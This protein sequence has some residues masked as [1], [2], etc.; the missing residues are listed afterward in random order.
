MYDHNCMLSECR[1]KNITRGG[2]YKGRRP[3][4]E[5]KG[6]IVDPFSQVFD[7]CLSKNVS[8]QVTVE[9]SHFNLFAKHILIPILIP[10][11]RGAIEQNKKQSV[12]RHMFLSHHH[13]QIKIRS[14]HEWFLR[15]FLTPTPV[16]VS[17][18][19]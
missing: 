5:G 12:A 6:Q 4:Q 14:E 9:W 18:S 10:V 7:D 19:M 17:K 13:L 2:V 8:N 16:L 3:G 11:L 15:A 1:I